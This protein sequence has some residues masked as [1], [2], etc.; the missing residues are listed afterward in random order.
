MLAQL[1]PCSG[2]LQH[3]KRNTVYLFIIVYHLRNYVCIFSLEN[4]LKIQIYLFSIYPF[5]FPSNFLHL[6][7]L[8]V[9]LCLPM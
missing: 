8:H 1:A 4:F 3:Y 9:V 5:I 2:A 6:V 7:L